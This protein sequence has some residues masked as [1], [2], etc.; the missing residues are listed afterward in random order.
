MGQVFQNVPSKNQAMDSN[1]SLFALLFTPQTEYYAKT[2]NSIYNNF[3]S[4]FV[5]P[6]RMLSVKYADSI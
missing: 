6:R 5:F 1:G 3:W 2:K 4:D